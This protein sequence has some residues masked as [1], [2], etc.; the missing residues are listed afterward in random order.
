MFFD[1]V[2]LST[3]SWHWKFQRFTLNDYSWEKPPMNFC[4][5]FWTIVACFILIWFTLI[6]YAFAGFIWCIGTIIDNIKSYSKKRT[7]TL[8]KKK[9]LTI[10]KNAVEQPAYKT[11]LLKYPYKISKTRKT[12]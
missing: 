2:K 1:T 11:I 12:K 8:E 9:V 6:I 7:N 3:K 5:Y 10:K 4:P